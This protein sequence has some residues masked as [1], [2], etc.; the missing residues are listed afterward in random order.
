M[1]TVSSEIIILA[2]IA[3]F[4]LYRLHSILGK[5]DDDENTLHEI[6]EKYNNMIDISSTVESTPIEN[7]P[8]SQ[9]EINLGVGFE[10]TLEKIRESE[11]RFSLEKFIKGAHDAFEIIL[12]AFAENDR[13]T[14]KNLLDTKMYRQF[15]SEIDN[16]LKN[17]VNLNISLVALPKVEIQDIQL[18]NKTI[19]ITVYYHS[20]QITILRDEKDTIIEGD[21]SQVDDVKDIWTFS[22]EL[23]S[24]NKWLLVEANPS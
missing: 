19:S 12:T 13:Q 23:N 8:L 2:V 16:R 3:G 21:V 15:S 24:G 22:R 6:S 14:L 20:Q 18:R 7:A 9:E 17:K 1:F 10:K 4:I 5:R 11:P